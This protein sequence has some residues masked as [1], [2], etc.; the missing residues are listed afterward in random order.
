MLV[1]DLHNRCFPLLR[2]DIGDFAVMS[3]RPSGGGRMLERLD[4]RQTAIA[5][6]GNGV[7][8]TEVGVGLTVLRA[9][10]AAERIDGV[11]CVQTG[12][13]ALELR[14]VWRRRRD[15]DDV[16]LLRAAGC[17][18]WGED[19]EISVEDVERLEPCPTGNA[20][21]CAAS[22]LKGCP[23]WHRSR[24]SGPVDADELGVT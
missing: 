8:L 16:E 5:E 23:P 20:G 9:G 3:D 12:A 2:Y 6:L 10:D 17:R 15:E 22:R 21:C 13:N 24:R 1:T 11:Q 4:G 18:L 19:V 7:R 14:V